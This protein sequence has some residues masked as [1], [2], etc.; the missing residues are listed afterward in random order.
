VDELSAEDIDSF[1]RRSIAG[2]SID[3]AECVGEGDGD[4]ADEFAEL[5]TELKFNGLTI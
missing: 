2:E 5:S 1:S 3:W 4:D